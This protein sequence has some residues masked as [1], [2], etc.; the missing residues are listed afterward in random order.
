MET[1]GARTPGCRRVD[2]V[3]DIDIVDI[4]FNTN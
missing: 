3:F 2:I 4:V 1:M